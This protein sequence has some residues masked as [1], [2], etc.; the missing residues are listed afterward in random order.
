MP[1]ILGAL[2]SWEAGTVFW[3]AMSEFKYFQE[4]G[5][6]NHYFPGAKTLPGRDS[7]VTTTENW[8]NMP[9]KKLTIMK[10]PFLQGTFEYESG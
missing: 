2:G 6:L 5:R 10:L 1:N 7:Q 9:I 8:E 3:G 4:L